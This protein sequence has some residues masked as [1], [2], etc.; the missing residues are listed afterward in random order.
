MRRAPRITDSIYLITDR[1]QVAQGRSLTETVEEALTAG[2]RMIQLREKDLS[3]AELWPLCQQLR[4]LTRLFKAKLII[5][6]RIDLALAC[7][8]DGVHLGTHSLPAA[9][10]RQLL[11]PDRLIGV[12]THS[13]D[14]IRFADTMGADFCTFGPVFSTPSKIGFGPPQG[15]TKL[16]RA[17]LQSDMPIFALGGIKP[18]QAREVLAHGAYGIAVIS[19]IIAADDP[20]LVTREFIRIL[21]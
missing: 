6:D 21:E 3:A 1:H 20:A 12:S 11:G 14:E 15:L 19:A 8:A 13:A 17:C 5:N 7:D 4:Q 10:A 16:Q 9:E 2:V 18:S